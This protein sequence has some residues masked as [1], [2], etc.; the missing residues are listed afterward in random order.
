MIFEAD[1]YSSV[2]LSR[3]C[4]KN[5]LHLSGLT[6]M[7]LELNQSIAKFDLLI[8]GST[9]SGIVSLTADI[10]LSSAKLW[11]SLS[12]KKNKSF[13]KMLNRTGSRI[14]P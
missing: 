6:I 5:A 8:N 12:S 7:E 10:V 3:F 4:K 9:S 2:V 11:R 13:I 1:L 14:D